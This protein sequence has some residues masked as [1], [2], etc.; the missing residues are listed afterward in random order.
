M[1][2]EHRRSKYHSTNSDKLTDCTECFC[3]STECFSNSTECFCY[4][5]ECFS[6]SAECFC[7][8]ICSWRAQPGELSSLLSPM[9]RTAS[10]HSTTASPSDTEPWMIS[11]DH[12]SISR[13]TRKSL[14]PLPRWRDT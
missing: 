13:S 1:E 3:Y 14:T 2:H 4:S 5:V 10:T 9:K 6:N 7:S 11:L 12:S 8:S